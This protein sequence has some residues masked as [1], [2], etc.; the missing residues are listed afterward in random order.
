MLI[1]T[2]PIMK[3]QTLNWTIVFR[4]DIQISIFTIS[5]RPWGRK[6]RSQVILNLATVFTH[7]L[8]QGPSPP[9]NSYYLKSMWKLLH[10]VLTA[11]QGLGLHRSGWPLSH[12]SLGIHLSSNCCLQRPAGI[13][14]IKTLPS[15]H[16]LWLLRVTNALFHIYSISQ[17]EWMVQLMF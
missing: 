1:F 13:L 5:N 17:I 7:I 9:P 3:E 14:M 12:S 11:F 4:Q 6:K 10:T 15:L 8:L 16:H 2:N